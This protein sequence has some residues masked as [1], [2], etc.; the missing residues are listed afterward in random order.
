M[1]S[2]MDWLFGDLRVYGS[3]SGGDVDDICAMVF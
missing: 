2:F 1:A 3:S